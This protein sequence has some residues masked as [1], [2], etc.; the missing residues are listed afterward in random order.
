LLITSRRHVEQSDIEVGVRVP[1]ALF[2][3]GT[4]AVARFASA[5]DASEL[6]R[7]WVGDHVTFRGGQGYDGLLQSTALV[8]ITRRVT[9]Q[10][11]VYLLPL[12]HPVPVAR[13]VASIA[14]LAPGRFVFGV[15]VGGDDRAEVA[16]CGVDPATRGRRTDES[17]SIV[18]RL[19]E[20]DEVD[21]HGDHFDLDAVNV[22]P[23]PLP[24][25]PIVVG[26]RSPGAL[27]RAGRLSDGWLG[28][29]VDADRFGTSVVA[30]EQ[31][32][33]DVGT[34]D[35][36]RRHG[37][38]AWCGFG[39]SAAAARPA[40]AAAMEDLYQLPFDRFS[41]YAPHGPPDDV[42]AALAPFVEAGART[43]LLA[44]VGA[45]ADEVLAGAARVR[46]LL[47]QTSAVTRA[48]E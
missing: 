30:V 8:A 5:V 34:A 31:A 4:D 17:L 37:V 41:R 42:A 46:T 11:A 13:Q 6:D 18:R 14:E 40:L 28:V 2:S 7:L 10:T 9:V 12:R 27:R 43:V 35:W 39:P 47:R 21:H 33:A 15:G 36:P 29:F 45:D 20:G 23:V 16:A 19:L 32:A 24:S 44:A 22:V 38:L 25:V 26:G 48:M 3:A 1:H